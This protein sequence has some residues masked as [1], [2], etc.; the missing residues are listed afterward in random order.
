MSFTGVTKRNTRR[1]VPKGVRYAIITAPVFG[2]YERN[3]VTRNALAEAEATWQEAFGEFD[4]ETVY[5]TVVHA[6]A[7]VLVEFSVYIDE[8]PKP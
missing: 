1:T 3:E 5:I 6:T 2:K 7:Q 4:W 8:E